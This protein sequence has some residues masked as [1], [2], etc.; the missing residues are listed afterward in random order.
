V[1]A[2]ISTSLAHDCADL[3]LGKE[4]SGATRWIE[5]QFVADVQNLQETTDMQSA[6]AMITRPTTR[7][8]KGIHQPRIYTD[9]IVRYGKYGFLTSSGEPHSLDDALANSNWKNAMNL[10]YDALMKNKTWHLVPP[11]KDKNVVGCKWIY[12]IKRKQ[13][14]SLYRYKARLVAKGFKQ[15]Y[16][17]DYDDTFSPMVK[18]ATI[19][20]I[21]SIAMST[22]WSL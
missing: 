1:P 5:E 4:G 12:K 9:D 18:I 16:V 21:L 13:D 17:I 7:A 22:G 14:G 19:C 8:Q 10:E 2:P 3:L 15:R 20:T 6:T 11:M